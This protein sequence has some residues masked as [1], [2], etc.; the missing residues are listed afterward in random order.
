MRTTAREKDRAL[1][2]EVVRVAWPIMLGTGSYTFMQFFDRL[3]LAHYDLTAIQAALPAGI[4]AFAFVAGFLSLCG[5]T[6]TLVAHFYGA[7]EPANCSRATFQGVIM[8]L[9]FWPLLAAMIP[10]GRQLL[11]MGGHPPQVRD[12]EQIYFT[13]LMLGSAG[14]LLNA[15]LSGFFTGRGATRVTMVTDIIANLLNIF[16]DYALIFGRFGFPRLGIR[17]A[18]IATA[19]SGFVGPLLLLALFLSP[20]VDREYAT[21]RNLRWDPQL[22]RRMVRFGLPTGV[23][24][25]L[26][27]ASFE[28]FVMLAGR[29]GGIA[30]AASNIALSVNLLAFMPL[31]GLGI[32]AAVLVGKY[33]GAGRPETAARV[34]RRTLALGWAYTLLT[35]LMFVLV[36]D[37]LLALFLTPGAGSTEE[38]F[39]IGRRLLLI[40]AIWGMADAVNL[41]LGGALKGAGDTRFVMLFSA[42][43]AWLML[44]PGQILIVI[45]AGKGII[46][47]WWWTAAYI[48]V[49]A[50]GYAVRFRKGKWRYIDLLGRNVPLEPGRP[51]AEALTSTD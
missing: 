32:T 41:I 48:A 17:G 15:A 22:M 29:T 50:A 36:P 31:V 7:G 46:A 37:A 40:M 8:A 11:A 14:P 35:G 39:H 30:L 42:A 51:A 13:I 20:Q 26:D 3:F 27:I 10:L 1:L 33:L 19:V 28:V 9:G 6:N 2:A 21:R 18:G 43:V 4:L 34:A 16:L 38:I 24:L 45:V 25:V 44:V 5:Y 23:Q 12:Q 49:L 47:S